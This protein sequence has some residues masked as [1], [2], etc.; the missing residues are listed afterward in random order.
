MIPPYREHPLREVLINELHARPSETIEAPV[1]LSHLA[2]LT[3]EITDPSLDH[4]GLLCARMGETVPA[5]GATRF[6]ANLGGLGLQFERHTEFCTYT[7]QRRGRTGDLPFDQPALDMVPPDWLATLPGQV[8]SAVHLVVEPKDT[9]EYS[10]EEL[11]IRHFAGNPVVGSAVGG[12]AAFAYSD[13]R[14]HD[15]RCLRMLIR[16]VDLNPRHAGRLV[17]RLLELNTYRALALL[18]L[19]MARE[20]SPGLRRIDMVLAHVAARM[21][22][23]N[24]VDSDAE[25]LSELSNLTAEVE[26]LAAANSYRIAATRAYHAL[27]QRRLEEL[28][29]VRLDGVVT[30]GAFMDRR[31]TPAMATVDSVSERIESLSERGARVASLLRA[32]VEVDLQAQNKR[33]L[34]SMNRRARIQLRLQEAVE[35]LSVVAISY[36]LVGLVGYMAK[37]VSGAGVEVKESVVTAIAVPVIVASVWLVLRRAKRAMLNRAD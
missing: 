16:D 7:F 11:S 10:I 32:R 18:A 5:K 13:L 1:R 14:L 26:S 36:Y 2:V 20:S 9:P 21:A 3:G 8:L 25:L 37:G 24:G 22:D 12:G 6:N 23:P 31:L 29:E 35:G 33:L 19:P 4:L 15:D 30:F 34:E 28:R 27:V 17:Q